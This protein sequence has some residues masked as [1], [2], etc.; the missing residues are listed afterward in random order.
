MESRSDLELVFGSEIVLLSLVGS[1]KEK[2]F[3]RPFVLSS[4]CAR[5][6]TTAAIVDEK[7]IANVETM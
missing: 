2:N 3:F 5:D 6:S 7:G 4:T 1:M